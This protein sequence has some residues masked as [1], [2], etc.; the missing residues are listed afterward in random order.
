MSGVPPGP[1]R[2]VP[3]DVSFTMNPNV[4][5]CRY[6]SI[7]SVNRAPTHGTAIAVTSSGVEAPSKT[8]PSSAYVSI[9]YPCG[10]PRDMSMT[11]SNTAMTFV[12]G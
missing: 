9:A 3:R 1:V 6:A 8:I 4:A 10:I 11:S 7:T 5:T 2:T 12:A